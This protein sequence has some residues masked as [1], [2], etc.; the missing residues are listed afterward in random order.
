MVT[1]DTAANGTHRDGEVVVFNRLELSWIF[2]VYGRRVAAG[3]WRDYAIDWGRERAVFSIYRRASE[4]PIYRV[5]KNPKLARRQGAFSIVAAGG[6]VLKR[7]HDLRRVLDVL[8]TRVR[9]VR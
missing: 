8:D 9:V 1:P 5:E 6:Q 4:V 2:D 3:D 7:G